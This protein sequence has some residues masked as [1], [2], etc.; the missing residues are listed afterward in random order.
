MAFVPQYES[1]SLE[2]IFEK[3]R[4]WKTCWEYL[5]EER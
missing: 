5:P 2:R 3:A 1:L 4:E